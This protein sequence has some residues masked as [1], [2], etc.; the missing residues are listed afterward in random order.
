MPEEI[1]ARILRQIGIPNLLDILSRDLAPTDLQSL[2]LEAYRLRAAHETPR[3]VLE[4]YEQN[5]FTRPA[6]I[7]PVALRKLDLLAFSLATP[8]FEPIELSPLAPLGS[9]SALAP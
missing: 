6:Q 2:L 3:R 4:R 1:T 9:C 8:A 7:D 5:P